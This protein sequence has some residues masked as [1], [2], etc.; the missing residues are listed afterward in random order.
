MN[1]GKVDDPQWKEVSAKLAS[2]TL[3]NWQDAS[4]HEG[5][6]DPAKLSRCSYIE[7]D[8][9]TDPNINTD[10]SPS[11][12]SVVSESEVT[13][14]MPKKVAKKRH[15][16]K[17]C[18]QGQEEGEGNTTS[19]TSNNPQTSSLMPLDGP[20][21]VV[22]QPQPASRKKAKAEPTDGSLV[23]ALYAELYER[24]WKVPPVRDA[25]ANA[26]C[27]RL[28][29]KLGL[30]SA[31]AVVAFFLSHN[32]SLY[33]GRTHDLSLCLRDASTLHTQM[34]R[35]KQITMNEA[36]E[37]EKRQANLNGADRVAASVLNNL[38]IEDERK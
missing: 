14:E 12:S 6:L 19:P 29:K 1:G 37:V 30:E 16:Q 25:A 17:Q 33:V 27:S 9:N 18:F 20:F 28:V 22:P 2:S 3:P 32:S 8:P 10:V 4:C 11:A 5:Q 24:R 36:V 15:L 31:R 21:P 26:Q 34:M 7:S 38:R 13:V 23:W 35:G